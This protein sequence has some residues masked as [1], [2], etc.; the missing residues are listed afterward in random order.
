MNI[1]VSTQIQSI[2]VNPVAPSNFVQLECNVTNHCSLLRAKPIAHDGVTHTNKYCLRQRNSLLWA[3]EKVICFVPHT[4][5]FAFEYKHIQGK[6]TLY[7][8]K[9]HLEKKTLVAS[10][11]I[12]STE[13]IKVSCI[14]YTW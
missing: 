5:N 9:T 11:P 14:K 12:A 3:K 6:S 10:R 1:S 4:N 13:R 2:P 8:H 7:Y